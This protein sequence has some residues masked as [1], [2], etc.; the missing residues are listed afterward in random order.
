MLV[1]GRSLHL[2][3]STGSEAQREQDSKSRGR[4][5]CIDDR[6]THSKLDS[7]SPKDNVNYTISPDIDAMA[8]STTAS[9]FVIA[10]TII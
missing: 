6:E 1:L 8:T 3:N 5:N 2:T 4:G 7:S 10:L 9:L